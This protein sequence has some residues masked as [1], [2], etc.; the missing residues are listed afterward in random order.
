MAGG[1]AVKSTR[2]RREVSLLAKAYGCTVARTGGDHL[3]IQ[4][5]SGWFIFASSTPSDS[6]ALANTRSMLRRIARWAA[7]GDERR[8]GL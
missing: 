3:R 2:Y 5:P 7:A 8:A 6:H 1:R 4:H